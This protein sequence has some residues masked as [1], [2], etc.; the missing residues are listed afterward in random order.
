LGSLK[1]KG[2]GIGEERNSKEETLAMEIRRGE[3]RRGE[4]KGRERIR[5]ESYNLERLYN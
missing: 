4:E 2:I 5:G 3:E 1:E